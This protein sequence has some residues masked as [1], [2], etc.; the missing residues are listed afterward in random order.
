MLSEPSS[1]SLRVQWTAASGP[2]TGYKVQYTPLTGLGQPLPSERQEVNI[3]AGETS[4]WLQGLRPLTEYQVTVVALYANSIGEA[5]SG[6]ART[7]EQFCQPLTPF[8]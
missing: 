2:V 3:P 8:T 1:Q 6:T 7:S 5:V 4:V